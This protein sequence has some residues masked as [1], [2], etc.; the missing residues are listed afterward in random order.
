MTLT[1]VV[2]GGTV[3]EIHGELR[4]LSRAMPGVEFEPLVAA[5]KNWVQAGLAFREFEHAVSVWTAKELAATVT[6][7]QVMRGDLLWQAEELC[8]ADAHYRRD[9]KTKAVVQPLTGGPSR[10]IIGSWLVPVSALLSD[11]N[12]LKLHEGPRNLFLSILAEIQTVES[13]GQDQTQL[14]WH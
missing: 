1:R 2:T 4:R 12:L 7:S 6:G 10:K 11:P 13:Q 3:E 9:S 14:R 8:V 5:W